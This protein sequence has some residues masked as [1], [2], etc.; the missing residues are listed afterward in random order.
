[1]E[2]IEREPTNKELRETNEYFQ[3]LL[4]DMLR[5]KELSQEEYDKMIRDLSTNKKND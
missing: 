3:I 2:R 5:C 4:L 1:M